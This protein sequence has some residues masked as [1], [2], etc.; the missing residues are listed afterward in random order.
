MDKNKIASALNDWWYYNVEL[1][2]SVVTKGIYTPETPMLPRMMMRNCHLR[3]MDCLDVGSMEGIIPI[4]MARQGA[5]SILATDAIPHCEEKMR[6]LREVYGVEFDFRE[7]GLLY[8]LSAKLQDFGGFDFI[9]LSGVLYH[10]FS[11]MHVLAGI[12]PLLKKNGLMII[13]TNV[14]NQ[15]SHT[16]EFNKAGALQQEIN[17]FWYHSIPMLEELVR[18]F[19][20]IPI[21]FLYVPHSSIHEYSYV[22]GKDSG[23]M[24]VVCRAVDDTEVA[25]Q[26]PWAAQAR[27]ASWEYL[28]LCNERMLT[29]QPESAITYGG[30]ETLKADNSLGLN[31]M[32]CMKNPRHTVHTVSNPQDAHTLL[33]EHMS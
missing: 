33:L 11:P 19:K 9:N 10:V 24:S 31:L 27:R 23:F 13:S 28:G 6:L 5:K 18:F 32:E 25:A 26:D 4:L 30:D 2:P 7:I 15:N 16:L 17:T 12:R 8:D 1:M 3:D 21:D 14:L 29:A 22:P 20:L